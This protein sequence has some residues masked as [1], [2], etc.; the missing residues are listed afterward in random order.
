[1]PL[2]FSS[3]MDLPA[4]NIASGSMTKQDYESL[5]NDPNVEVEIDHPMK[6]LEEPRQYIDNLRGKLI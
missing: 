5:K 3:E 2:S 6:F 4:Y 1:M